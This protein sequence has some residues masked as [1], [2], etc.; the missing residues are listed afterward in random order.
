MSDGRMSKE[1]TAGDGK[2]GGYEGHGRVKW[3]AG[4]WMD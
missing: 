2:G 1:D 4:R 3:C